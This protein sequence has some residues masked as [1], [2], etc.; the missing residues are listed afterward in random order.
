MTGSG[1]RNRWGDY[2]FTDVDPNDDMTV[3]TFQEYADTPANNWA[4]RATQLIA[5]APPPSTPSPTVIAQGAT[6]KTV[7]CT[8]SS[9]T[10][11]FFDPGPATCGGPAYANHLTATATNGVVVNSI[12]FTSITQATLNLNTV[13]SIAN[14]NSVVTITNP[15]GQTATC[16][17]LVGSPLGVNLADFSA[18]QQGDYVLLTWETASELEN[19]GFNLYRGTSAAGSDRQLN[20][21][22]IPS[23]SQGNPGGFIYT[24]E[25]RAGLAPGTTYFYWVEDV[26]I[27]GTA[28]RHGPVSLDFA[29]PTAVTLNGVPANSAAASLPGAGLLSVLLLALLGALALLLRRRKKT[30]SIHNSTS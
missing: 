24:W 26:D 28:T 15:D 22:L 8:R 30:T 23:Q 4:V 25:D 11:E 16:T 17:V 29:V 5:P 9:G 6:S 7:V 1:T 14:T 13:A 21:T 10:G 12:T 19:R 3:W 20:E 2:S 18:S 27:Y